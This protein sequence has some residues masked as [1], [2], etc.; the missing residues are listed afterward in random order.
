MRSLN[1]LN[2]FI[3]LNTHFHTHLTS[4]PSPSPN[5]INTHHHNLNQ[6]SN[7]R[8]LK[9][10]GLNF[11]KIYERKISIRRWFWRLHSILMKVVKIYGWIFDILIQTNSDPTFT[12]L[13]IRESLIYLLYSLIQSLITIFKI[14]LTIQLFYFI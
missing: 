7:H 13:F 4:T 9:C 14:Y 11:I 8:H 2:I 10:W 12:F 3:T 1:E 5:Y 6:F